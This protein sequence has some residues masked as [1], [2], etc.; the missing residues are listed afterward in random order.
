MA[1]EHGSGH[2]QGH[3][4]H[5]AQVPQ[6]TGIPMGVRVLVGGSLLLIMMQALFTIGSSNFGRV[7]PSTDSAKVKLE[8]KPH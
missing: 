6:S 4:L 8:A 5:N 1:H 2:D 3:P 7:W